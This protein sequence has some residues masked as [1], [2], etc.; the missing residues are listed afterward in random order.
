MVQT[1]RMSP[2][3]LG[4]ENMPRQHKKGPGGKGDCVMSSYSQMLWQHMNSEKCGSAC[5]SYSQLY[6]K[7]SQ[8]AAQLLSRTV[9]AQ[10]SAAAGQIPK[11]VTRIWM[12]R[13]DKMGG[14]EI[15]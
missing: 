11:A 10:R 3:H 12:P 7:Q 5:N 2:H 4:E 8:K 15:R 9:L 1:S 14:V 13:K 6:Q